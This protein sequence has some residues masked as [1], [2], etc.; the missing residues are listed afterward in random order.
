M[1]IIPAVDIRGGKCVRLYQGDFSKETVFGEDPVAVARAW[2]S[3]GATRLHVVDLDGADKGQLTNRNLIRSIASSLKIPVQVGGGIRT[4]STIEDVLGLGM[5]RAILGTVAVQDSGLVAEAVKRYGDKIVVSLD[6][7]D[8]YVV[9]HGW[10]EASHIRAL[11]MATKLKELGV[12]RLVYT[13]IKRDGTLTEPNFE[14]LRELI[15]EV[16][17]PVIASG[18]VSKAVH[19]NKLKELGV[20][21]AIIGRA[22]YTKDLTLAEALSAARA[23]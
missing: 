5:A 1:E 13:D 4:L 2:Q 8:G 23:S 17:L 19:V 9:T 16:A 11:D 18:G 3:Q 10:K 12:R 14:A 20:E 7:R 6:A 15:S 21:A 22:L